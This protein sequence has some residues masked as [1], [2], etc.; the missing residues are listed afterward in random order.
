VFVSDARSPGGEIRLDR[1]WRPAA[2]GRAAFRVCWADMPD[3]AERKGLRVLAT[4]AC[5]V[6]VI[7][8]LRAA[9]SLMLPLLVAI[10]LAILSVPPMR[11]LQNVGVP[12]GLAIAI[13]V[14]LAF[15]IVTL[16][17]A[18]IGTSVRQFQDSLPFYRDRLNAIM[19]DGIHW[20]QAQGLDVETR[21]L[22][23]L[24][25]TT[26]LLELVGDTA[27]GM[28]AVLSN[29]LLVVLMLIFMLFE[30]NNLPAKMRR[31]MRDP[32]L[33]LSDFSGSAQRVQ[34]Y[35]S[36]K[37]M[38][39]LATG[40]LVAILTAAVGLD[41]PLLWGLVAFL[42]NFVPSIGSVIAA[43]PAV[44][45]AL[46]QFGVGHAALVSM[47]YLVINL[48]IG[49]GIEPRLM[50]RK[51]GLSTLVVF[52]SMVF[53]G[54]V[55]GPVGMLLSVPL[56]VILKIALEHSDDFH[57]IAVLL[58]PGDDLPDDPKLLEAPRD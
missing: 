44:L 7:A 32:N 39:S 47:G 21:A 57:W 42:F 11:R 51:L 56:T 53:W 36:I 33:D 50:G 55:W 8:G 13:V 23:E 14:I 15:G 43:V 41:F 38:T 10:F 37:S 30:A 29:M 4:L 49:N 52:L 22:S 58:G 5:V 27:A 3:L 20:L 46:V 48:G 18:V 19:N 40:I 6:V 12:T 1:V 34:K 17:S 16:V 24:I 9:S 28:L 25:D 26:F 45:L 35:L 31:A 54:W 2:G